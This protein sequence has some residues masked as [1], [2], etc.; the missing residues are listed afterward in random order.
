MRPLAVWLWCLLVVVVLTPLVVCRAAS[1]RVAKANV[2]PITAISSQFSFTLMKQAAAAYSVQH[3]DFNLQV[4]SP[5]AGAAQ[6]VNDFIAGKA[7]FILTSTVLSP[8]QKAIRPEAQ[9]FPFL[10]S[11]VVPMYNLPASAGTAQLVMP[12]Q[13]ICLI[14]RG[15]VTNWND[16]RLQAANPTLVMPNL[17]ITVWHQSTPTVAAQVIVQMCRKI[18]PNFTIAVSLSPLWPTKKYYKTYTSNLADVIASSIV[19]IPGAYALNAWQSILASGAKIAA[20][21]SVNGAILRPTTDSIALNLLELALKPVVAPETSYDLTNPQTPGAWPMCFVV[22]IT[23]DMLNPVTTC[24]TKAVLMD[25]IVW[26][27][28]SDTVKALANNLITSPPSQLF[29]EQT[30]LLETLRSSMQC[31]G[32]PLVSSALAL[33]K[34]AGFPAISP[35]LTAFSNFYQQ[36]NAQAIYSFDATSETLAT[37]RIRAGEVDLSLVNTKQLS[38]DDVSLMTYNQGGVFLPGF[39]AGVAVTF[40]LPTAITANYSK[41]NA[42]TDTRGGLPALLPLAIDLETV[43][44]IFSGQITSWT[45]P[46]ILATSP[47]VGPWFAAHP[48]VSTAFST[49][50]CCADPGQ[51][52]A[53]GVLLL[54]S[55]NQTKVA[56]TDGF[57]KYFQLPVSWAQ[58]VKTSAFDLIDVEAR[59]FPRSIGLQIFGRSTI[60]YRMVSTSTSDRASEFRIVQKVA[61]QVETLLAQPSAFQPCVQAGWTSG[62]LTD[63]RW[64]P[65]PISG[66]YP[67]AAPLSIGVGMAFE[68][69]G[70]TRGNHS[71][72]YFQWMNTNAALSGA[73]ISSGVFRASDIPEIQV[74]IST[75]LNSA[76]CDGETLLITL[77][78]IWEVNGAVFGFGVAVMTILLATFVASAIVLV[79]YRHRTVLRS[80]SVPFLGLILFGLTL[81]AI[82]MPLWSAPAVDDAHCGAF[83][84]LASLGFSLVFV[85]FF[86]KTWRIYLIFS[87]NK[88]QVVKISNRKLMAF[89]GAVFVAE[90]ILMLAWSQV[91]P[92]KPVTYYRNISGVIHQA[93]HC[94]VEGEGMVFV[95]LEAVYKGALLLLGSLLA[96]RT[97][98]V[99]SSF[100]E[101]SSIALSI[102]SCLFSS[103]IIG[104]LIYFVSA[105]EDTL[106]LLMLFLIFWLATVTWSL[107]FGSKFYALFS[108]SEADAAVASKIDSMQTE[109]SQ[110]GF[111]FVSVIAMPLPM[112]RSYV[113]ALE[114]QLSKARKQL[115]AMVG[116]SAGCG[117]GLPVKGSP[118]NSSG[119]PPT[120]RAPLSVHPRSFS[121]EEV[122]Q[123]PS[124]V[125]EEPEILR[126]TEGEILRATDETTGHSFPV[127]GRRALLSRSPSPAPVR[128]LASGSTQQPL[129]AGNEASV[130]TSGAGSARQSGSQLYDS[131]TEKFAARQPVMIRT[132]SSGSEPAAADADPASVPAATPSQSASS[133]VSARSPSPAGRRGLGGSVRPSSRVK[134]MQMGAQMLVDIAPVEEGPAATPAEADTISI[135][136]PE[137]PDTSLA[138]PSK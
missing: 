95:I 120:K 12:M 22:S 32:E 114:S 72:N 124:V 69:S 122:I 23:I 81:L 83:M 43:A 127:V 89:V 57:K 121:M 63:P 90:L 1:P 33:G 66:C 97:R 50:V 130:S 13:V 53:A 126:A 71:L 47:Q 25:F 49:V 98:K 107:L 129:V 134:S 111:S 101:S 86:A 18:D 9:D 41:W 132:S 125:G 117:G 75:M 44:G 35:L 14:E 76:T 84:W 37:Y 67:L 26:L 119:A 62:Q 36:S 65:G 82:S 30:A 136:K 109:K 70:C 27:F 138:S 116:G 42:L 80:S 91:S 93:T 40:V 3:P 68:G 52:Q 88:L 58:Q 48:K 4:T 21:Q 19:D 59:L 79:V 92:L 103:V 100:N 123:P 73:A 46:A 7:D 28:S 118:T 96:F 31:G 60:S 34:V 15:V 135:G 113:Q 112:L 108:Q 64:L 10:A 11:A 24:A 8:S 74:Y 6:I 45:D 54:Q 105:F 104:A 2:Y 115:V 137:E 102:Y 77:P 99:S 51:Q 131:S 55:L 87:R 20:I 61:D 39:Y 56:Q 94:S 29:L 5:A 17:G 38:D 16:T 85:P 78:K 128:S 133:A 106:I 110:G